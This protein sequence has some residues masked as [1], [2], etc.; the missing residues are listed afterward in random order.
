MSLATHSAN[1]D[2]E[3]GCSYS[4]IRCSYLPL[5]VGPERLELPTPEVEARCSIQ[6]SY[7]PVTT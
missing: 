6:L 4:I 2:L 1:Y 5:V 3:S 7:G